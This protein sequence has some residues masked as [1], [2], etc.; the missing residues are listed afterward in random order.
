MKRIIKIGMFFLFISSMG[1]GCKKDNEGLLHNITLSD[2][3]LS[4][5]QKY[6]TGKWRL[7][8]AFGG[9]WAHKVINTN[10]SYMILSPNHITKG[11]DSGI[12]VDTTL[13]W[14]KTDIGT[15]DFT[16]LFSYPPSSISYIVDQIEN[17]TLVIT[18][19]LSDGFTFY[20]TKY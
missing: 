17:D 8:Y 12:I 16:Y 4:V 11:N 5:I 1:A 15:N 19:Y 3:P 13:V 6:I 10:N 14:V 9:L 18:Q 20:Y 7:K 2:K